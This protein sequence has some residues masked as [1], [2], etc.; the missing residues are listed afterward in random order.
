[1][2]KTS[3]LLADRHPALMES[4]RDLLETMFETVLM[5]SDENSLVNTLERFIPDLVIV[6]LELP[7]TGEQNVVT[8][9]NRYDSGLKFIVLSTQ[10]G[11]EMIKYC[12]SSGASG[13][14]LKR[15][16]AEDLINAVEAIQNGG[17]YFCPNSSEMGGRGQ[18]HEGQKY[19][20]NNKP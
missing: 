2:K 17:G 11:T 12:K 8:L 19:A 16:S 3:V 18:V 7:V 20:G 10:E 15:S 9:L 6:D 13:Y 4:I 5:V 1:M 14:L